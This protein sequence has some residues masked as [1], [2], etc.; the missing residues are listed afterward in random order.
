MFCDPETVD[1]TRGFGKYVL[2]YILRVKKEKN[3][4]QDQKILFHPKIS[5]F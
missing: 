5:L 2:C 3:K 4:E 1:V